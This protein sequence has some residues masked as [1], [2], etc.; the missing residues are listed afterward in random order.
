MVRAIR[1]SLFEHDVRSPGLTIVFAI[2]ARRGRMPASSLPNASIGLSF[3][4]VYLPPIGLCWSWAYSFCSGTAMKNGDE[5]SDLHFPQLALWYRLYACG[6]R[7]RSL[8]RGVVFSGLLAR[9][10]GDAS[11]SDRSRISLLAADLRP[12]MWRRPS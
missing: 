7:S 10:G 11:R 9:F 8:F 5:L 6:A 1:R 3:K 4:E 2:M 12:V